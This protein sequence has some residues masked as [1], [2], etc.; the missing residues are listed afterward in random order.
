MRGRAGAAQEWLARRADTPIA[1]LAM[2][3]FRRYFEASQNSGCAATLYTFLSVGPLVLAAAGLFDAVGG[4]T[5]AFA[6]RLI[7]HLHLNGVTARL[8]EETFGTAA[9]NAL[10]ATVAAAIGFLLWGI[11]IGQIY[12]DVY[13]RAWRI[14][15]RT[16][17]DQARFTVWFFVLSGLLCVFIV[18]AGNLRDLGWIVVVPA[19]LVA[20]TAFWLWTPRLLLRAKIGLRP[21]LPGALL[22]SLVIGGATGTSRFW[23]GPVLNEDGSYFGSFGVVLALVTWA[24][25]LV[26]ISM[27]CAVF[28]PVWAEWREEERRPEAPRST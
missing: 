26:T 2:Q 20:S 9:D 8:V 15:V 1:R 10:A 18:F 19:W 23:L 3:W 14:Q 16:L 12:Q 28:S 11:G 5:N 25:V 6:Q 4:D 24:F 13:A 21:L 7:E 27:V 17:S 22:A